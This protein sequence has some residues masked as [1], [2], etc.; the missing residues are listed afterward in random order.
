MLECETFVFHMAVAGECPVQLLYFDIP[1]E[2]DPLEGVDLRSGTVTVRSLGM[3]ET[4]DWT[5]EQLPDRIDAIRQ[6]YLAA[7][8][9]ANSSSACQEA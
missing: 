5:V 3:V 1:K 9:A 7:F 4:T 2:S 6:R 8:R